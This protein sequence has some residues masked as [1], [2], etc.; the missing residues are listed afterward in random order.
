[1]QVSLVSQAK[2][3]GPSNFEKKPCF[4]TAMMIHKL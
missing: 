3:C 1:L 4:G 2:Q